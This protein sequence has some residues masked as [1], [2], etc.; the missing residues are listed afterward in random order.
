MVSLFNNQNQIN[1]E[2]FTFTMTR[3]YQTVIEIEASNYDDALKQFEEGDRYAM[4]LEQCNVTNVSMYCEGPKVA[5]RCSVTGEVMNEG[6]VFGDG[7]EYA[8]YESGAITLAKEYGYESLDD[9]FNGDVCYWTT[10]EDED[11]Y[12][13]Q[14]INGTL[15]DISY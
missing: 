1:M 7:E 10:W 3:V 14:I 6:W 5:R 9:A 4:E 11:D 8:K 2:K 13:Y 15:I 12:Q